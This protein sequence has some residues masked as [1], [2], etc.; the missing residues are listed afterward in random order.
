MTTRVL[1]R[2]NRL[3]AQWR[4][5]V[6]ASENATGANGTDAAEQDAYTELCDWVDDNNLTFT[7]YDP[8][9]TSE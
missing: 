5:A 1:N 4:A 7:T 3:N 6:A 2:W 9:G 8:R